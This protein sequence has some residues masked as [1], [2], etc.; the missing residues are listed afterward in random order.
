[1]RYFDV[2][3]VYHSI[4]QG[5]IDALVAEKLLHLLD[6]H[7]FVDR[8]SCECPPKFVRVY[9]GY[10]KSSAEFSQANLHAADQQT[11]IRCLQRYK[12]CRII[13]RSACKVIL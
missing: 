1:M 3:L 9:L 6:W 7:A 2:I 13:V 10:A 8:H 12:Q 5:G 4:L 11:I